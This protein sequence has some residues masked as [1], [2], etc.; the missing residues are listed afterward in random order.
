MTYS[1]IIAK[2]GSRRMIPAMLCFYDLVENEKA[3]ITGSLIERYVMADI[4]LLGR[5]EQYLR[6]GTKT[7][8]SKDPKSLLM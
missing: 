1:R 5:I 2:F 6:H 8:P 4:I 7:E 3:K